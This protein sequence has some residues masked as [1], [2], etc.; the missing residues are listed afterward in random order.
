MAKA[1]QGW[2]WWWRWKWFSSQGWQSSSWRQGCWQGWGSSWAW[3]WGFP[4][5]PATSQP[6]SRIV[7]AWDFL[8]GD[9]VEDLHNDGN[10]YFHSKFFLESTHTLLKM[11][12]DCGNLGCSDFMA[13][14]GELLQ[15]HLTDRNIALDAILFSPRC[16]CCPMVGIAHVGVCTSKTNYSVCWP[17]LR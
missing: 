6:F 4:S 2:D 14:G 7:F 1:S 5:T 9:E 12:W 11:P 15:E 17:K 3:A 10:N 13:I 8:H 16:C